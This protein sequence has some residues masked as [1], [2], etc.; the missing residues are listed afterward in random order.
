MRL[1]IFN[2][3]N[4]VQH[5]FVQ[6]AITQLLLILWQLMSTFC[7]S[8]TIYLLI[9]ICCCRYV[10]DILKTTSKSVDQV[11]IQ[12]NGVWELHTKPETA[13]N[14]NGFASDDDDDLVEITKSGDSLRMGTPRAYGTPSLGGQPAS[15][16]EQS[17]SSVAPR[18]VGSVSSKRP[19]A[20]IDLTSSG[21][22]DDEPLAKPAAKRQFVGYPQTSLPSLSSLPPPPTFRP[23]PSPSPA[24][25]P[26][27]PRS[28]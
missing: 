23:Y 25:A 18:S 27:F 21:D 3:K 19:A 14:T 5:G 13:S 4:K 8:P 17:S 11:T 24:S 12:P 1:H 10:K 6:F 15:S 7:K 9:L 2:Y 16:R 20:V 28:N 22:E 26:G